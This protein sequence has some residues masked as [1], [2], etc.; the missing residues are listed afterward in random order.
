MIV[1][2][3]KAGIDGWSQLGNKGWSWDEMTPYYRK[4]HTMGQPSEQITKELSLDY[5]D[6]KM[7][8]TSGPIQVSYADETFYGPLQKAWPETFKN[9]KVPATG[10]HISG[11][12]TGGYINPCAVDMKT[13]QRSYAASAYYTPEVAKRPNLDVI[14]EALA[15]K[16]VF[17]K[18][19]AGGEAVATGAQFKA[20][21]GKSHT[22]KVRKEVIV[23]TG[24]I[25]SPQ[26]L[27]LSGIGDA[28]LLQS[29]GIDVVVDNPHV[30][31]NMQDHALASISYEVVDG[32]MTIEHVKIPGVMEK[33]IEMHQTTHTGPL[34][35]SAIS[36][37]YLP[38]MEFQTP[39]GRAEVKKMLDSH[40]EQYDSKTPSYPEQYKILR[41]IVED[42]K[43][44]TIQHFSPACQL[45]PTAGPRPSDWFGL[46][47]DGHYTAISASLSHPFSRGSIHI[48]SA[49]PAKPPKIDPRYLSNP[50]DLEIL[51]RH[52]L[53]I[54]TIAKTEPL[55]SLLKPDGRRVPLDAHI[56]SL[57]EAK[58]FVVDTLVSTYHP[59]STCSMMPREKGGVVSDRLVVH[60]TKNV[61]VCDASI[62][63][64]I[65]RGN[66]QTSVYAVAE[67]C[68]DLIIGRA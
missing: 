36:N 50:L 18:A 49:D 19:A 12:L 54:E 44:S 37:A 56:S 20:K 1:Y 60:G 25:T 21:D 55:A 28:K 62:F 57:E 16:I 59:A 10:D 27:E 23:C 17:D 63:P 2:P 48:Q 46:Q 39:E 52:T 8:G 5:M 7:N 45:N 42:E 9:L 38:L 34:T 22:I 61:R 64:L 4:F 32:I 30:G 29:H 47:N 40:P 65:P 13:R 41:S 67:K 11:T 68:A 31:E 15:E 14:T 33:L 66:I 35:S 26:I 24:S 53:Y 58:K 51:A 6:P 43:D 3:S